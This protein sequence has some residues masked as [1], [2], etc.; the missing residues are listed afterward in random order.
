MCRWVPS[1]WLIASFPGPVQKIGKGFPDFWMGPENKATWLNGSGGLDAEVDQHNTYASRAFG[2]L[3][4]KTATSYC[5]KT[6]HSYIRPV[7]YRSTDQN[8]WTPLHRPLNK[9]NVFHCQMHS[10]CAGDN[11]QTTMW[12]THYLEEWGD[13][14]TKIAKRRLEG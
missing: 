3:C 6:E 5:N 14:E 8:V 12:A 1:P 10:H 4:W 7:C 9:L 11:Q 13:S 2:A